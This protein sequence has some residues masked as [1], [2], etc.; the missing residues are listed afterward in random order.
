MDAVRIEKF[1]AMKRYRKRRQLLPNLVRYLA[2]VLSLGLFLSC[3]LWLPRARSFLELFLSVSLPGVAAAVS[4]P[5]CLFVLGNVIVLVL[6]GESKLSR[7]S[8]RP[9][10]D[11][12]EEYVKRKANN[13]WQ[14]EG[15]DNKEGLVEK[16]EEEEEE[17]EKGSSEIDKKAED[18][19]ARINWERR[20]EERR[21]LSRE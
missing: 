14:A 4:G 16:E 15:R 12:Y 1:Q 21:L 11:I 6:V 9:A 18:F 2:A 7:T 10:A 19:I 17:E 20:L 8:S 13:E 5:K 3:P